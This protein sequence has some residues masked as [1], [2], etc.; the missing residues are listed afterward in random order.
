MACLW[1]IQLTVVY[2]MPEDMTGRT[3]NGVQTRRSCRDIYN[4]IQS[5][6]NLVPGI[7]TRRCNWDQTRGSGQAALVPTQKPRSEPSGRRLDPLAALSP[8]TPIGLAHRRLAALATI[9]PEKDGGRAQHGGPIT[10]VR[11]CTEGARRAPLFCAVENTKAP[12]SG[13]ATSGPSC[14]VFDSSSHALRTFYSRALLKKFASSPSPAEPPPP[15]TLPPDAPDR[16]RAPRRA[17]G[18]SERRLAIAV[19]L[20]PAALLNRVRRGGPQVLRA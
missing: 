15:H 9:C 20:Q 2:A 7:F 17:R 19:A 10:A 1:I 14:S 12:R 16:R 13:E 5:Y 11:L 6:T 4:L 18:N 8:S 3:A